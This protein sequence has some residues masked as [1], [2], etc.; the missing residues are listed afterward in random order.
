MVGDAVLRARG[1][2]SPTFSG[3]PAIAFRSY[4]TSRDRIFRYVKFEIP[5]L[6]AVLLISKSENIG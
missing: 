5:S 1:G 4:N 6:D 2:Q 3:L